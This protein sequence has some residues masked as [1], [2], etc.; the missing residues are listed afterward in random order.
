MTEKDILLR[1]QCQ[2]IVFKRCHRLSLMFH[3]AFVVYVMV[4]VE[5]QD[6]M[7]STGCARDVYSPEAL[8]VQGP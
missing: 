4:Q 1:V 2:K 8:P 6:K 3:Q 5:G 7:T